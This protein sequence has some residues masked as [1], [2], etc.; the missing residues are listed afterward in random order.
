MTGRM[1]DGSVGERRAETSPEAAGAEGAVLAAARPERAA[2][3]RVPGEAVRGSHRLPPEIRGES[4]RLFRR[5][6]DA[7]MVNYILRI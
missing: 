2:E 6:P 4:L 1:R 7:G 3:R 5:G